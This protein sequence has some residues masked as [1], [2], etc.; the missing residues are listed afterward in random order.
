MRWCAEDLGLSLRWHSLVSLVGAL[1]ASPSPL[2]SKL[3]DAEL[4]SESNRSGSYLVW[5]VDWESQ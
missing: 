4:R 3:G 5:L 1:R 2:G